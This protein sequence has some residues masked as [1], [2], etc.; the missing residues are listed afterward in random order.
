MDDIKFRTPEEIPWAELSSVLESTPLNIDEKGEKQRVV[1]ANEFMYM[2]S[3][4][5]PDHIEFKE[6]DAFKH[7]MTRNYV[8][9]ANRAKLV[10]KHGS[11]FN[12]GYFGP[13]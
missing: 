5:I 13:G 12:R 11:N 3:K 9:L 10:I 7:H 2:H 1:E 8:Y 6:I 4:F